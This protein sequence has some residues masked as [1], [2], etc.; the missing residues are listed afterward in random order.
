MEL[1]GFLLAVPATTFAI[2]KIIFSS[3]QKTLAFND[4]TKD[5]GNEDS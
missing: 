5:N 1:L 4:L 3:K 2:A